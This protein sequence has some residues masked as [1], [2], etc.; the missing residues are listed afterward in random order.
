MQ[1]I[2]ASIAAILLVLVPGS[3]FSDEPGW[4]IYAGHDEEVG[5]RDGPR[6]EAR[7]TNPNGLC[8]DRHGNLFVAD[9]GNQRIRKIDGDGNVTTIAGTGRRGRDDGPALEASFFKAWDCAVDAAGN[10]YIAA[11]GTIRRL[12][13]DGMVDTFAN[14]DLPYSLV[15]TLAMSAEGHLYGAD[16]NKGRVVRID[17]GS[18]TTVLEVDKRSYGMAFGPDGR[19]YV[20]EDSRILRQTKDGFEIYAEP[21][22]YELSDMIA[23]MEFGPDGLL[24]VADEYTGI[25]RITRDGRP[26]VMAGPAAAGSASDLVFTDDGVMILAIGQ[27]GVLWSYKIP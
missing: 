5:Y 13:T 23:G 26:E 7:F 9:T 18:F 11:N 12:R 15:S 20:G 3:A 16:Q 4:S 8:Q 22:E 10:I 17:E 25:V 14:P 21:A 1:R 2:Q 6:L 24:Y 27:A 19:I